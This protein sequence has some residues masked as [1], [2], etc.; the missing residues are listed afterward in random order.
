ML[1]D[2][3]Q[4]L[5]YGQYE[6]K[7]FWDFKMSE[8]E[9]SSWIS[10][11]TD[12]PKGKFKYIGAFFNL[13]LDQMNWSRSTYSI[14]DWLADIGGLNDMLC[15]MARL[16]VAPMASHQLAASLL[17]NLFRYKESRNF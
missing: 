15:L 10:H 5:Q 14:L 9:P 6:T 3:I 1:E 7:E 13:S 8:A 2:E 12:D 11:P 16:C 4:L 17:H